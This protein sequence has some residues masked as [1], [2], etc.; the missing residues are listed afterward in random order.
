MVVQRCRRSGSGIFD[1]DV[2]E[3]DFALESLPRPASGSGG[4]STRDAADEEVV[5][6]TWEDG[7]CAL[8]S[9]ASTRAPTSRSSVSG[10]RGTAALSLAATALPSVG[11][12]VSLTWVSV[13]GESSPSSSLQSCEGEGESEKVLAGLKRTD[14]ACSLISSADFS[15]CSPQHLPP[16]G[17]MTHSHSVISCAQLAEGPHPHC[18]VPLHMHRAMSQPMMEFQ[19]SWPAHAEARAKKEMQDDARAAAFA[20]RVAGRL[21]P[22]ELV[23]IISGRDMWHNHGVPHA[24]IPPIRLTDGPFGARG[25]QEYQG[26]CSALAPCGVALGS[27]WDPTLIAQV[28]KLIGEEA[29]IKGAS[30]LLGP[31]VNVIRVPVA[32]RT[33]ECFG[34]DPYHISR[35]AVAYIRGVQS[36]EGVA[37][38]VKHFAV[39]DQETFRMY[40]SAEVSKE[41]LR[42][43]HLIPFQ[44]AV[45]EANVLAVMTAYNKLNGTYCSE[46]KWL[47]DEL[48]RKEW[49]FTGMVMCDWSGMHSTQPS[50]EAGLDLEMPGDECMH[51]G[52]RL[53]ALLAEGKARV[54]DVRA[55][56]TTVL[57]VM[58]RLGLLSESAAAPRPGPAGDQHF[59]EPPPE[60][61]SPNTRQQQELLRK[62]AI[63]SI[64]LLKNGGSL[65]LSPEGTVAV[66]GPNAA[67]MTLQGGGSCQVFPNRSDSNLASQLRARLGAAVTHE[68]GC[69]GG[70]YLLPLQRPVLSCRGVAAGVLRGEFFD[71][72]AGAGCGA[73]KRPVATL[74]LQNPDVGTFSGIYLPEPPAGMDKQ[75]PWSARFEGVLEPEETG[76][77]ELGLFATGVAKVF[78]NG[79]LVLQVPSAGKKP[80]PI[81]PSS[82]YVPEERVVLDLEAGRKYELLLC[83]AST[84]ILPTFPAQCHLGGRPRPWADEEELL[85][86][87]EE[88]AGAADVAVVVVGTDSWQEG[89]GRDMPSM[90][91]PGRAA[92][93]IGRV[94]RANPRTVV[95]LNVGSPKDLEPWLDQADAVLASWFGGQEAAAALADALMGIGGGP[96]GR[97]P[98]T[99]PRRLQ[100]GPT[101]LAP[102]ERYPGQARRVVYAEEL[103]VGYRW[104]QAQGIEPAFPFG[105][106]LTYTT[107]RYLRIGLA[108][109]RSYTRG[110]EMVVEITLQNAGDR[111]GSEVVQLYVAPVDHGTEA[112][113]RALACFAKVWLAPGDFASVALHVPATAIQPPSG[114]PADFE[115]TVG[116]SSSSIALR[117]RVQVR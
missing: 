52:E 31:T 56:A 74:V 50:L 27:T 41:A 107:F 117:A 29:K 105:H 65:P 104:Y 24:G 86:R 114:A 8:S 14:S 95:C 13:R 94:C 54:A 78:L 73:A 63:E 77:F 46:N 49:G 34:E 15:D 26:A 23:D 59:R 90:A 33:F 4:A 7:S 48:L 42:K 2:L 43:L 98:F 80:L 3:Q 47:L 19:V 21:S 1:F 10:S 32:G 18:D 40:C 64:V 37:A 35:I 76:P 115:L 87:A 11:S 103:M 51:Y 93:L 89:E 69:E 39:N 96:G 5:C 110:E 38:C 109:K 83:W 100:D 66:I 58:A 30:I 61:P 6:M 12:D 92:E 45:Q 28:G 25:G 82:T 75:R 84:S 85:R 112:S 108:E 68:R 113:F 9:S 97:L 88:A 116:P 20:Q 55:R 60:R 67:S 62:A 91:L 36:V 53:K 101:G 102:N 79:K 70:H 44:A 106:G 111:H 22:A 71:E 81:M 57:K 99:W 72:G 16:R 17:M